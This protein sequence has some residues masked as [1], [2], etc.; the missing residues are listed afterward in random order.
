MKLRHVRKP[1]SFESKPSTAQ[2]VLTL[3]KVLGLLSVLLLGGCPLRVD[4]PTD[5][6]CSQKLNCGV[7]ASLPVCV[8]CPSSD[9][10]WRGCTSATSPAS[11][12][13]T[14]VSEEPFCPIDARGW[15]PGHAPSTSEIQ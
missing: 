13:S 9:A 3:A 1:P 12:P 14:M 7:C 10:L 15:A 6:V 2:A 11:C 4:P 5:A 8:W